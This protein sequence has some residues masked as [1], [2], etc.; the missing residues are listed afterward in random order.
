MGLIPSL[1]D[2]VKFGM[3]IDYKTID[4][5]DKSGNPINILKNLSPL[6]IINLSLGS[7]NNPEIARVSKFQNWDKLANQSVLMV[8]AAGNS[9][10]NM[11]K[12]ELENEFPHLLH[13]QAYVMLVGGL[14]KHGK[15]LKKS[16]NYNKYFVLI[17][18]PGEDLIALNRFGREENVSG[19]SFA[20]PLVSATAA[21][22]ASCNRTLSSE[23]IRAIIIETADVVP[24]LKDKVQDGRKLNVC[25]AVEKACHIP[26]DEDPDSKKP[27]SI[28][29]G[30]EFDLGNSS[31]QCFISDFFKEVLLSQNTCPAPPS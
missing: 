31:G 28:Q 20:A 13:Q 11:T 18:A 14:A 3:S 5:Y 4:V 23:E 26:G 19:T 25:R 6:K 15:D 10:K 7:G 12:E 27:K 30:H 21:L 22:I 9:G 2:T 16:S 24:D 8:I 29:A 17:A 1:I